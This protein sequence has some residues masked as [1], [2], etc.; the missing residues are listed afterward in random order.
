MT[1]VALVNDFLILFTI[2]FEKRNISFEIN[3]KH[4]TTSF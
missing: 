2:E 4:L 3:E 1:I